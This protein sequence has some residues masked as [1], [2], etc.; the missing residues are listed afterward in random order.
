MTITEAKETVSIDSTP[1]IQ[2]Q[3]NGG[4]FENVPDFEQSYS[5]LIPGGKDI[6]YQSRYWKCGTEWA[7]VGKNWQHPGF[8]TPS[9]R[10]FNV[11]EDGKIVLT[12]NVAKFHLVK[13]SDGVTVFIRHNDL[14]LWKADLNGG[15]GKGVDYKLERTVQKGDRIRFVVDQKKQI[16]CDTTRWDPSIVYLTGSKKTYTASKAF[17][18]GGPDPKPDDADLWSYQCELKD[19]YLMER[20]PEN[21]GTDFSVMIQFEWLREDKIVPKDPNSFLTAAAKHFEKAA[22]LKNDLKEEMDEKAFREEEAKWKDLEKQLKQIQSKALASSV[23]DKDLLRESEL[24]Y[25]AIRGAKRKLAFSNPLLD[26]GSLLFCKRQ[27][28]SYSHLVM[29]YFGWRARSG[30]GL[31]ILKEPGKSLEINDVVQGGL[32]EGNYLEPKLSWDGKKIVF[33]YVDLKDGK[34]Y[35]PY[36]VHFSDP[37]EGFYHIYTINLDGSGLK[38]LTKDSFDDITP[39]WLADGDIVFSSTRRLGY[40]RCFWWGFGLRWQVYTIHRMKPDGSGIKQLSWHDT[41]EWFPAVSPNGQIIYARWDYIDR[42]AVTHQNLWSMRPDGTNPSAVWGNASPSPHCTF[43]AIPVPNSRKYVFTAS[44]H[45]SLTGG[46]LV[47]LDP[48]AGVDGEQSLQRLTPEVPFPESETREIK[49]FYESPYPLSEKYFLTSYSPFKLEWEG[50]QPNK[51]NGLGIYL[52]DVFGNRELVYRDPA[53]GCTNAIPITARPVPPIL[54]SQLPKE[55]VPDYGEMTI[56]DVYQGLGNEIERGRIKE[57]RVFQ[58]LPK[59]TRDA[60][61]PAIGLAGEENARV[62]LGHVPVEDDGSAYFRVPAETPVYLQVIDKDGFAYQTMRSL[63]YLQ[64]GE[65]VSCTG[66]HETRE[67]AAYSVNEGKPAV[68]GTERPKAMK[69]PASVIEPGPWGGRTFS[70]VEM[71]QPIWD[72]HCVKCHN[73][74]RTDGKINLTGTPIDQFT[75]SYY[76][77]CRSKKEFWGDDGKDPQRLTK[78]LVTRYGGRNTIQTAVPGGVYGALGSRLMKLLRD[79]HEKVKLSDREIRD[80]ALWIDSNAVFY[81]VYDLED[82][83]RQLRGEKVPLP[84]IQ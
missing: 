57:I 76:S 37:D 53:I 52:Y 14:E 32:P 38:Q 19:Q 9:V 6:W 10:C 51:S 25:A 84:K 58:I 3:I 46:S 71:I 26:F 23:S 41:N 29:Q 12:G 63:T 61:N 81:G 54:A 44:A 56:T 62:I 75:K 20:Y 48:S 55:N 47:L 42:D 11:P 70:Y 5:K 22:R 31:F 66:C 72:K 21:Y 60:D 59:T 45:H 28:T 13:N 80:I 17:Y 65:K 69:R 4:S 64:R 34:K 40:A 27:P 79:G 83:R 82:Q 8:D 16:F 77:L 2:W 18:L 74:E 78:A 49:E 24:V 33:A 50:S 36:K 30:G 43:Q 39:N 7:R 1:K 68:S 35:D 15:D 73:D 67:S